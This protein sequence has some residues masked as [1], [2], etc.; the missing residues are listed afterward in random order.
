M[1]S[2]I[3]KITAQKRKGRYNVFVDG[4][5][6]LAISESVLIKYRVFKGM[7]VN[8]KVIDR[9]TLADN[10]SKLYSRALNY[11]SKT[12]KTESEVRQ[13]L[14]ELSDDQQSIEWVINK[15]KDEQLLDDQKYADSFVRTEVNERKNGPV[16]ITSKLKMKKV[17]EKFIQ[18]SLDNYYPRKMQKEIG[19][20]VA[21]KKLRSSSRDSKKMLINKV[22]N[23]LA[24][25]GFS[26]EMISEIMAKGDFSSLAD[27]DSQVIQNLAS[28][29][30]QKY[31]RQPDSIQVQK[32]KQAL[33]RKGFLMDDI[34][35]VITP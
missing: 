27:Q 32:T 3:T 17:D 26:Y 14:S 29:Y 13:K 23:L 1:A 24:R 18:N 2:T 4:K 9:L 25:R 31:S 22:K 16:W 19:L 8:D 34:N 33:F 30:W 35:L 10:H 15:L 11:L 20:E 21:N 7:E 28:R 6:R 5:Y 12:L